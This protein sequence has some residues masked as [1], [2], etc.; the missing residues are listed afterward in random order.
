MI[1]FC[2][3]VTVSAVK[4]TIAQ[5]NDAA[6]KADS[7]VVLFDADKI[8]GFAHIESAVAHAKRSFAEGK[9][10]ARS[11]SMEILVYAS[12]QRQCSLASKF[13]LHDGENKVYVLIL[14]GDEEKAAALVREIVSEC[15]PF[16]PNEERLKAEFGI[17]DA[18][19]EAAGE[20]RIEELVIERVALVD[21][22]K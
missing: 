6:D 12:G 17:T 1:I 8:A 19:M 5:I 13:G 11:L 15:E 4:E 16:A 22:W 20:N 2:G 7:T 3:T 21:A 9:Q 18:E 14:D 10:I